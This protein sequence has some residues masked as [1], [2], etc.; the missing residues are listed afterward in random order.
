MTVN[1]LF[2]RNMA[3][4]L[5]QDG[6]DWLVVTDTKR[7]GMSV[8]VGPLAR[9][10]TYPE[11]VKELCGGLNL[12]VEAILRRAKG[13]RVVTAEEDPFMVIWAAVGNYTGLLRQ[14]DQSKI[15]PDALR[16][17]FKQRK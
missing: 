7:P 8:R 14:Y 15:K 6:P 2:R 13:V 12:E 1:R 10:A 3:F 9:R 16:N 11:L 5:T 17:V 4:N